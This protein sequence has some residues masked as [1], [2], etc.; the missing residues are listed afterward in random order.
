MIWSTDGLHFEGPQASNQ[1]D[2]RSHC[3]Q[4]ALAS[5]VKILMVVMIL[6]SL[7][8]PRAHFQ[9][10]H[11]SYFFNKWCLEF[12]I[13]PHVSRMCKQ[14]GL[15]VHLFSKTNRKHNYNIENSNTLNNKHKTLNNRCVILSQKQF[16]LLNASHNIE[17]GL[18]EIQRTS[19]EPPLASVDLRGPPLTAPEGACV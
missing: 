2:L 8:F 5:Y 13:P 17:L 19:V 15:H 6:V 11:D 12:D 7:R 10:V 3:P 18:W 9:D 14:L 16:K 1:L 4:M